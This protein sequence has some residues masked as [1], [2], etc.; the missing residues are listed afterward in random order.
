MKYKPS[1]KMTQNFIIMRIVKFF[2]II[3]II[4]YVVETGTKEEN[5]VKNV[6]EFAYDNNERQ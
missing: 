4:T 5:I 3:I 6:L 1:L 2:T